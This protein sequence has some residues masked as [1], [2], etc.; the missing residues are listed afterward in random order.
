MKHLLFIFITTFF[1]T[2]CLDSSDKSNSRELL[3]EPDKDLREEYEK[4]QA[5]QKTGCIFSF[6][7]HTIAGIELRNAAS[8]AR[9]LGKDTQLTGDS[10]HLFYSSNRKQVLALKVFAGDY[11]N[12]VSAFR[13]SYAPNSKQPYRKMKTTDFVTE[14]GIHLGIN[15]D[16][17]TQKLGT[18][19]TVKDSTA[20]TIKLNYRIE[21]DMPVYFATYQFKNDKLETMAFG[22][23]YP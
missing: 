13:V 17:L 3:P 11:A 21:Q 15:K 14:K 22:Y 7:D 12:Q 2:G 4:Q 9:I 1:V 23:E 8:T 19:Y 6:P 5:V 10:T 16:D 18:C 20:S